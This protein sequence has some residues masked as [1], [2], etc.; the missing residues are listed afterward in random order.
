M[1]KVRKIM[2]ANVPTLKKEAM[3]E[4]AVRLLA[5][6]G[7]GCVVIIDGRKPI[8]IVT[9][10]DILRQFSSKSISLKDPVSKIMTSPVTSMSQNTSLDE[11][12]KIIDSKRYRRY[13]IVW[14]DELIG[15]VT[16]KDIVNTI[17]DNIKF[18]RRIQ[19]AVLVLFVLF[20]FFVFAYANYVLKYP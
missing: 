3:I 20:E 5:Q 4:D 6:Q 18:H 19:D 14:N 8:G 10:L 15:V 1:A 7:I 9:E 16:K 2:I 13:P 12:L 17:S 11:A